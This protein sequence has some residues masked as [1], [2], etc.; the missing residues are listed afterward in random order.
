[1]LTARMLWAGKE[2]KQTWEAHL[3]LAFVLK[4]FMGAVSDPKLGKAGSTASAQACGQH[5]TT[6]RAVRRKADGVEDALW[7]GG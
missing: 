7:F 4:I 1:M 2:S 5:D 6:Q 3:A